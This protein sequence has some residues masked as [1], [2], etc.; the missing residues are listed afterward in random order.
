MTSPKLYRVALAASRLYGAL[1]LDRVPGLRRVSRFVGCRLFASSP[2]LPVQYAEISADGIDLLVPKTLA[3]A[4]VSRGF[5]ALS[6]RVVEGWLRPGSTVLDIGANI[7]FHTVH[8][9]RRVG[10][11]GKVV[12]L[13]PVADN[14]AFLEKNVALNTLKQVA[15]L[16]YAAGSRQSERPVYLHAH[17]ALHSFY[18]RDA[19]VPPH[20]KV[21]QYPLDVLV[22][23]PEVDVV[24]ID[25]EGAELEVLQGMERILAEN[26]N[27]KLLVEWN[28]LL[29]A[30]EG[31]AFEALPSF[32]RERGFS[33]QVID[34][35]ERRVRSVED[36]LAR[37]QNG[38]FGALRALD[39][40]AVR[41]SSADLQR[42]R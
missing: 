5:D 38:T 9:A 21:R 19:T 32:L 35:Q 15:I 1:S 10:P 30:R 24:K 39:I 28:L 22:G 3:G 17:G 16:P 41:T 4:Y 18:L 27:V 36:V 7:G 33:L 25:T 6:R 40:A 2:E 23:E 20:V 11:R 13:E 26:P 37:L 8:F 31:G 29:T 34:D 42:S 12:A 14:L